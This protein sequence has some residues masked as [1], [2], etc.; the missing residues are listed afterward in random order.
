M[1]RCTRH[2][3]QTEVSVCRSVRGV[4]A[5]SC[6]GRPGISRDIP[7]QPETRAAVVI[8]GCP[9]TR[10]HLH[11]VGVTGSSPVAPT[12]L[13]K[14]DA[15][16]RTTRER[17]FH[18]VRWSVP[19]CA[20]RALGHDQLRQDLRISIAV[21]PRVGGHRRSSRTGPQNT[22]TINRDIL[23]N[24]GL[25]LCQEVETV[26]VIAARMYT[27]LRYTRWLG[28]DSQLCQRRRQGIL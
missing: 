17:R 28:G 13:Q 16:R 23:A 25:A 11:T 27:L 9:G 10:H 12:N 7:I 6:Y 15:A 26:D 3:A 22:R 18:F 14:P 1:C 21:A 19:T 4:F 24:D 20:G 2:P 5:R 8:R